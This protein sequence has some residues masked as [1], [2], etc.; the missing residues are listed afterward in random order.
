MDR[1]E[2]SSRFR[3]MWSYIIVNILRP[4]VKTI[5]SWLFA[6]EFYG[7]E[8][9]PTKGAVIVTPNHVSYI[10]PLLVALAVKRRFYFMTWNRIFKIPILNSVID[11]FGAFPVKLEGPDRNAM[12][13]AQEIIDDGQVLVVFP[14]GA[15]TRDGILQEFKPGAF[16]L[17]A[18][19]EVPV[20]PV[21]VVGAYRVWP[22]H[23]KLPRLTGKIRVYY[24]EPIFPKSLPKGDL[25]TKAQML[26][27]ISR[28]RVATT[29][30]D[31]GRIEG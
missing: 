15:R 12:K 25:K 2:H 19:F 20:V 27:E 3:Q 4:M 17:A 9:I 21:T 31:E 1:K 26:T 24:H 13:R 7:I 29:A 10:D 30:I 22:P 18:R 16:R 5:F 8:N 28:E 11:I 23:K 6:M 14:E